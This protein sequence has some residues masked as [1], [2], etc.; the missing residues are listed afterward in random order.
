MRASRKNR[1]GPAGDGAPPGSR[2]IARC[3]LWAR[4]CELQAPRSLRAHAVAHGAVH[5]YDGDMSEDDEATTSD[6]SQPL[7]EDSG[8]SRPSRPLRRYEIREAI[9]R[10]GM[11]EVLAAHDSQI[12]RDV[13][14]KR[15]RALDPTVTQIQRFMREAQI[16]GRL[17]HPAVV[18]VHEL[19]RDP[20][21]RPFFAMKKLSGT[22][23]ADLLRNKA[24][25]IRLLRA[26]ADV[27]LA[28]EYAHVHGVIHRDL[29]PENIVLGE[30]GEV[31]VLDWG[32]AKVVAESDDFDDMQ[33][34]GGTLAGTIVG[35]PAWMSPEQKRAEVEIDART[36]VFA[37]GRILGAILAVESDAPPELAALATEA[38]TE[39]RAKRVQTARELG[40]RV[41]RYLDGDRDL[42]LRAQLAREHLTRA[43]AAFAAGD[44]EAER[45][46]A[47]QE[48]GRA[49][50][51]DPK[52]PGAA[53]LVGRL[54]LEPPR[55]M[56]AGVEVAIAADDSSTLRTMARGGL[57]G[58]LGYLLLVPNLIIMASPAWTLATLA[59][60]SL[61]LA[62]AALNAKGIHTAPWTLALTNAA[63]VALLARMYSPIFVAPGIAAM[64]AMILALNPRIVRPHQV[65]F[66]GLAM[67]AAMI[68]PGLL[69]ETGVIS[70]TFSGELDQLRLFAPALQGGEELGLIVGVL[71]AVGLIAAA[72]TIARIVRAG[73]RTSRRQ[74]HLQAWQLRQLVATSTD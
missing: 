25:R 32:I 21:G 39:D 60:V 65:L 36:D 10:G 72:I 69:E 31:Y 40:D 49:L 68:V 47:M 35:T 66:L 57:W 52:L 22:T 13:A 6:E 53:E 18:P 51:L 41:Q 58:M 61:A 24:A 64:I 20:D 30:F 23:L 2:L 54:M 26:F 27:C 56:P 8:R 55:K 1:A 67:T 29:K 74:L 63:C 15:M 34:T 9:G 48:A 11:G 46:A 33:T 4:T 37:L 44:G 71:Y 62:T 14:I 3:N 19:G 38:T 50:A 16:Q 12:G 42:A 45:R 7:A 28:I 5:P 73:E 70:R 59:V 17:D 43:Y